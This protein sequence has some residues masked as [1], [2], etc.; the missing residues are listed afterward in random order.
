M[1]RSDGTRGLLLAPHEEIILRAA[2]TKFAVDLVL[3]RLASTRPTTE[4]AALE[5]LA[6]SAAIMLDEQRE[7]NPVEFLAVQAILE[8]ISAGASQEFF[9]VL[10]S[11]SSV[12]VSPDQMRQLVRI[13]HGKLGATAPRAA[14]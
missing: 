7:P 8:S 4:A 5:E 12:T 1:N 2:V 14:A 10:C 13:L 11:E 9:K 6:T 3:F